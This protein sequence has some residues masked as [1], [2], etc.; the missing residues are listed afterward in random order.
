MHVAFLLN[1]EGKK[2][3]KSTG[4]LYTI[5]ELE[6]MGYN[7]E[8]FRYLSLQTSYRKPLKFSLESLE[9]AGNAYEKIKRKMIEIR[10]EKHTGNDRT[11]EYEKKFLDAVNDDL[12]MSKALDILWRVLDDF[13]FSPKKRIKLLEKFDKVLGLGI[14]NMKKERIRA[15]KEVRDLL[16]ERETYR[17]KKQWGKADELRK[18]IKERGFIIEDKFDGAVLRSI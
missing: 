12:N 7:S 3:S 14:K 18:M 15:S 6:K 16:K 11:K 5:S 13:N 10:M 2:V 8:Y 17:K 9:S 1:A 4:G